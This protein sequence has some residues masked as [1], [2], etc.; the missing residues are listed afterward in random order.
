MERLPDY[1]ERVLELV[2]DIPPGAVVTY[3]Q[4]ATL[5]GSGGARLVGTALSRYGS[6]VPW[7]RVVRADGRPPR[8]LA[9]AARE[10]YL[11][12]ATPLVETRPGEYRI[13]LVRARWHP[14][15]AR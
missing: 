13:D 7:W 2:E 15:D 12:E 3:G 8:G 11:R 4:L 5:V 6:D 9:L 10:H 1:V 14:G